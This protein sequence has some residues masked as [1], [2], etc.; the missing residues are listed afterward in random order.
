MTGDNHQALDAFLERVRARDPM[1]PEF[2]QAVEEVLRSIWPFVEHHPKYHDH[3]L[4]ERFVE[5]ERII[6]F[7]VPW[8][9]DQGRASVNA[10]LQVP[11]SNAIGPIEVSGKGIAGGAGPFRPVACGHGPFREPVRPMAR[12]R[13]AASRRAGS[14]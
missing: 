12:E 4:L 1:Q 8:T 2:H 3:G 6:V 10:G 5:P 14:G 11:M 7:R 13:A 9:D